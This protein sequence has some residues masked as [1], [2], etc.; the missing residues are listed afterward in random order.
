MRL[1]ESER[2]GNGGFI[3]A[4]AIEILGKIKIKLNQSQGFDWC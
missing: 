1:K 3:L 2:P 4:Q